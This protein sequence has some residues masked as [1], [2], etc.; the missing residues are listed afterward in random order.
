[1]LGC[2][3]AYVTTKAHSLGTTSN[4]RRRRVSEAVSASDTPL[5]ARDGGRPLM[6]DDIFELRLCVPADDVGARVSVRARGQQ[7][8]RALHLPADERRRIAA[9]FEAAVAGS[10]DAADAT[11]QEIGARL[12]TAAFDDGPLRLWNQVR[13]GARRLTLVLAWD[14][15]VPPLADLAALPWELLFDPLRGAFVADSRTALVRRIEAPP[16]APPRARTGPLR[17]QVVA[18][19]PSVCPLP[20]LEA[21]LDGLREVALH[22]GAHGCRLAQRAGFASIELRVCEHATAL[23]LTEALAG[24][25]D[26]LHVAAH[27]GWDA[28]RDAGVVLLEHA[29]GAEPLSAER[30]AA[31][32]APAGLT[33]AVL[34]ACYGAR[35][36]AAGRP[37]GESLAVALIRC[38]VPA[39]VA[40]QERFDARAARVFAHTFY[41]H[42][43]AG[44]PAPN[45]LHQSR[46]ALRAHGPGVDWAAPALYLRGPEPAPVATPRPSTRAQRALLAL[47]AAVAATLALGASFAWPGGLEIV[48]ARDLRWAL[49]AAILGGVCATLWGGAR[50]FARGT[51]QEPRRAWRL[52]SALAGAV[53]ASL[54]LGWLSGAP[55]SEPAAQAGTPK[56]IPDAPARLDP[57]AA[58]PSRAAGS[59]WREVPQ[60]VALNVGGQVSCGTHRARV[61]VTPTRVVAL[62]AADGLRQ[63]E[64]YALQ[65]SWSWSDPGGDRG[66]ARVRLAVKPGTNAQ[67]LDV[68][69]RGADDAQSGAG[70]LGVQAERFFVAPPDDAT[71]AFEAPTQALSHRHEGGAWRAWFTLRP[72]R[73]GRAQLWLL[74]RVAA[75]ARSVELI[76][77]RRAAV[78]DLVFGRAI[79]RCEDQPEDVRWALRRDS[80]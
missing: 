61:E 3:G 73:A 58:S 6:S 24:G 11:P 78:A 26:V 62:D 80:P 49:A 52:A 47:D 56:G 59:V 65:L 51:R 12:F 25:A 31:L 8:D 7:A 30:F 40:M 28:E 5:P 55:R 48:S 2:L 71:L 66:Y 41:A 72:S 18:A 74:L 53:V 76:V 60:A 54:P 14:P 29:G 13:D 38:G 77:R 1:M 79:A 35:V 16:A 36:A 15:D 33:L 27:G 10:A 50:A 9:W 69:P 57:P 43:L 67:L 70:A 64:L 75:T 19:S 37:G 45:A 34:N 17:V 46:L 4:I 21:E 68:F 20:E 39:V 63:A 23:Q 22:L 44:E 42:L 32:V